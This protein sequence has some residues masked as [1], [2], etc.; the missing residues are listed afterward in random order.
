MT[1]A[2][3]YLL[4]ILGNPTIEIS[5][6]ELRSLL[7]EIESQL[8]RSQVY[9]QAVAQLQTLLGSSEE[10]KNLF[11]AVGREAISLVF[12]N[13]AHHAKVADSNQQ[14]N[15]E[16]EKSS[17]VA[18]S[19]TSN[20]LNHPQTNTDILSTSLVTE[21]RSNLVTQNPESSAKKHPT[22]KLMNWLQPNQKKANA[23]LA[24]QQLAAQRLAIM[25]QIGQQLRQARE[26]R[27][28]C[29][30]DLSIFTHL[31]LHQMEAVENGDL[32]SLP[33]DILV[34]GFIRVMGNALGLNG[35]N[36]ANSLPMVN[37][38][39]SVIPSW[40]QPKHN[41]SPS[42]GLELRPI[43]LYLGYTALVAGT[44]GGLS[45]MSQ[46]GKIDTTVNPDVSPS[47]SISHS[48]QNSETNTKPGIKSSAAGISVGSDI[49][50][51]EAL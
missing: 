49:A 7:G 18:N 35:T 30:R 42:M 39:P 44:V 4:K 12:Q 3:A 33:E 16:L 10:A 38:V 41:N 29:L 11:K 26:A 27:G 5:Q 32:K 23:E 25:S 34:R 8:H 21:D 40:S 15:T 9:R 6:A 19:L 2:P 46:P 45:V 37:T 14:A 24:E 17:D 47:S 36:L 50:P 20:H 31:P 13:F 51:P 43:H 1:M 22:A 48:N 28:F